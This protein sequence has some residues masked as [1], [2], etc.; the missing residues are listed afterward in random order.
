MNSDL[1]RFLLT[2]ESGRVTR[3]HAC[4]TVAPQTD[5]AHA[6]G[7]ALLCIY[8]TGGNA[9]A[10]LV[11][12][13]LLHDSAEI[14]TGD[15]PY[16]TK[17]ESPELCV[18][19][20]AIEDRAQRER[21]MPR[22]QLTETERAIEKLADTLEGWLWCR[23]TEHINFIG[24]RWRVALARALSRF[25]D[26]VPPDVLARAEALADCPSPIVED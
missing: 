12:D 11:A 14:V 16:T 7:V 8:L 10:E 4:P 5:A 26:C 22:Y 2:L 17:R 15:I 1:N 25:K 18:A 3:Y 19:L 13:A 20:T 21:L 9:S 23:K 24:R 6:W